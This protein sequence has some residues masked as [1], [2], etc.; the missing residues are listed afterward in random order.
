MN[1][2]LQPGSTYTPSACHDRGDEHGHG[3][4]VASPSDLANDPELFKF[5]LKEIRRKRTIVTTPAAVVR[6]A[7]IHAA[8]GE[9]AEAWTEARE[10]GIR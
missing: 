7:R 10:T 4:Y 3:G 1:P 2:H 9:A 8:T 6:A 5:I